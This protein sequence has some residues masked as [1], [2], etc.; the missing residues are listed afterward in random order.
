MTW[1]PRTR[2]WLSI[3]IPQQERNEPLIDFEQNLRKAY[4][5]AHLVR[6]ITG[7]TEKIY[8]VS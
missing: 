8:K 3:M 6:R 7:S 4:C 5:L 2:D 1:L